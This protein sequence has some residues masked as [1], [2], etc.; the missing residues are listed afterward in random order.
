[1]NFV[2][3]LARIAYDYS[4]ALGGLALYG[5]PHSACIIMPTFIKNR[6]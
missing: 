5:S 2:K 6:G 4:N 3:P 1:M